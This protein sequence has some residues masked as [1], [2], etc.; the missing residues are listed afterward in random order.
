[1]FTC[2]S[3]LNVFHIWHNSVAVVDVPSMGYSVVGSNPEFESC[4]IEVLQVRL[5]M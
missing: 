1:M 5:V 3:Y 4:S 2:M